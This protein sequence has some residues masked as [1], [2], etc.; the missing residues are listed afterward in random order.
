MKLKLRSALLLILFLVLV[1]VSCNRDDDGPGGIPEAD[2][3]EQQIKDNDSL[4]KYLSTHYYNASTFA[5]PGN[6]SIN[7]IVITELPKDE[8]GEYLDLPD[9]DNNELLINAVESEMVTLAET[10]Y[11]YYILRLN[12]GGGEFPNFTDN[13]RVKYSGNLQNG[14]VFDSASS[15]IVFDLL[16]VIPGWRNVLTTFKTAEGEPTSNPDGT[17]SYDNYGLGMMFIPSGL[18]YFSQPPFGIPVYSNLI[19]KFEL[20]RADPIDHDGDL[21]FSHLEDLNNNQNAF[22]DDSDGDQIPNY[23]DSDDDNDGTLTRFEDLNENGDPT[24]DDTDGDGIPNYLDPDDK[25][26]NQSN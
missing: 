6:Y 26:S 4:L 14:N 20:Y 16:N 10:D 3:G 24:D 9:P 25:E 2:R 17:V 21:I 13:V 18:A 1:M 8:N 7:D 22:D 11:T 5:E 15:P 23:R 12:T 19:F